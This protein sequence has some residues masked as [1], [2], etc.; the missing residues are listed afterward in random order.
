MLCF[1]AA[2][3]ESVAAYENFNRVTEWC[4]LENFYFCAT[5]DPHIED[6]LTESSVAADAKY[7][8]SLAYW[9]VFE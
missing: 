4:A 3:G 6:T 9:N 7:F 2:Y 8:R 1:T 5:C